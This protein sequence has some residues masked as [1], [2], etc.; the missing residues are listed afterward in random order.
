MY[1][2]DLVSVIIPTYNV[3]K[4]VEQAVSSILNQT[5]RNFECIIVDDCSTDLTFEILKKIRDSDERI[6][7]FRNSKNIKIAKTL[8]KALSLVN[9]NYI[10]RMDG[11]DISDKKRLEYLLKFL[12]E[13][14]EYS[15]VGSDMY[16]INDSD[17][18]I[19]VSKML[20]NFELIKK[21]L[22]LSSPVAHIWLA[23]VEVYEKLNGYRMPPVEDY[24][25]LL[26][27]VTSGFKFSN[28]NKPLYSVRVREGN[29][30]STEGLKQRKAFF[31]AIKMYNQRIR[32]GKDRYSEIDFDKNTKSSKVYTNLHKTSNK[33]MKKAIEWKRRNIIIASFSILC[34][35][36]ISPHQLSYF[37]LRLL[38]KYRIR[39][40]KK[41]EENI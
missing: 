31:Y 11:D 6:K 17:K 25:F 22:F 13:N 20:H 36:L 23:K 29:T 32:E 40:Q 3:E 37:Y 35:I 15:L 28:L 9:G 24:D 21:N 30:A 41:L 34:S 8:N 14:Q 16:T 4:Y 1:K 12:K 38:Y 7:L 39:H 5:Y 27:M 26:R 10:L 19:G 18:V 2:N 33:L